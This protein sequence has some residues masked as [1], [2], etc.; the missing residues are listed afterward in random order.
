MD[1]MGPTFNGLHGT[2]EY[3]MH[4]SMGQLELTR[5]NCLTPWFQRL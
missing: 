5:V 2:G 1:V 4:S 3:M